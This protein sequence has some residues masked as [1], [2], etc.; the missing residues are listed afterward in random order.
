VHAAGLVKGL[1]SATVVLSL[2]ACG[3]GSDG[4]GS[5]S[6]GVS[7]TENGDIVIDTVADDD[8]V[9]GADGSTC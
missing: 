6:I 1:A 5:L 8:T 7:Q 3:S 4:D 2:A 9:S